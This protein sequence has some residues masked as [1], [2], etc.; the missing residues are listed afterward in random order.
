MRKRPH[1]VRAERAERKRHPH[2]C[3]VKHTEGI[4]AG[5]SLTTPGQENRGASLAKVRWA[6]SAAQTAA[7]AVAQAES[8]QAIRSQ[9]Q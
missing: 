2:K 1:A 6:R 3:K 9:N 8:K 7:R 5:H 4:R